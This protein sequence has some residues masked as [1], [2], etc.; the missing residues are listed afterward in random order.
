M[1]GLERFARVREAIGD[2]PL[3]AIGGINAR[4]AAEVLKAGADAVA[5]I[6]ALL[7]NPKAI[8][9][10]HPKAPAN[11]RTLLKVLEK[12]IFLAFN[13]CY[14]PKSSGVLSGETS[15]PTYCLTE[16]FLLHWKE[17]PPA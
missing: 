15:P 5:V 14:A 12:H 1:V 8:V 4:N 10:T 13:R 11:T 16:P 6:G 9:G 17:S 3:V 7:A 2:F